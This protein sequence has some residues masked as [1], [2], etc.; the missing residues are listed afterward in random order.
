METRAMT[1]ILRKDATDVETRLRDFG[2]S[3]TEIHDVARAAY[4]AKAGCSPLHPPTYPGTAG[5]AAAVYTMRDKK[6][7]HG[8]RRAD[9]GNFS[10]TINDANRFYIVVATGDQLAGRSIGKAPT[11]K[12]VKGMKTEAAVA[13]T[14]Q[15]T[16]F[17]DKA[18]D[19]LK[20]NAELANYC[21]WFLLLNI[22]EG[23]VFIELSSP[24]EMAKGK[25]T[26]WHER[27]IIPPL[28]SDPSIEG[29]DAGTPGDAGDF[30]PDV[31]I[32]V[33]RIA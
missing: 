24:S 5:W 22:V 33:Q 18:F 26:S 21:A 28:S 10:I 32:D 30:A 9:P 27:I 12:S 11:T 1:V 7:P 20:L 6:L 25:I 15:L 23:H 13:A 2:L 3:I 8:W 17:P 19:E 16:L 29:R 4:I 14:R 31:D